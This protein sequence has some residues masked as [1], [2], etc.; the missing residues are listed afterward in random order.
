MDLFK[1]ENLSFKYAG[2]GDYALKDINLTVKKGDFVLIS[3]KSGGG[4]TTLLKLLKKELSPRG[5]KS[6]TILFNGKSVEEL[7]LKDSAEQIGFVFQNPDEQTVTD[8]VRAE[9]LFGLENL[10]IDKETIMRRA[11]E[12]CGFLGFRCDLDKKICELSGGEKQLLNLAGVL[13]DRK[14]VV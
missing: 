2:A 11:A 1:I 13:A 10:G 5:E 9:L 8:G 12:V 6:G 4:K 14:S 7:S 3:G